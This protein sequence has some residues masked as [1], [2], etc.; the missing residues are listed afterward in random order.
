MALQPDLS[1]EVHLGNEVVE[2][3][4]TWSHFQ[5]TNDV[6]W[7]ESKSGCQGQIINPIFSN[8]G[9]GQAIQPLLLFGDGEGV[10]FLKMFIL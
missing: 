3:V 1:A 6:N 10:E 9:D 7:K 5:H 4:S 8:T 2:L